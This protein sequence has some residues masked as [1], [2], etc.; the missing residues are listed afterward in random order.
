MSPCVA[1][2]SRRTA[3]CNRTASSPSPINR[4]D[5]QKPSALSSPANEKQL[6][7][8]EQQLE[9]LKKELKGKGLSY[10]M[11]AG[12]GMYMLRRW[13]WEQRDRKGGGCEGE[14]AC[15]C[16]CGHCYTWI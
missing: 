1:I 3:I 11:N 4:T 16:Q 14:R 9:R 7:M 6:L 10:P 8:L 12:V 5:T 13:T 2:E 15:L